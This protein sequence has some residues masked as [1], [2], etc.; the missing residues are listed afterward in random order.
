M[1]NN[2]LITVYIVN[3]NYG[4]YLEQAINSV[5]RQTIQNYEIIIIDNDS[6]DDSVEIISKFLK[7]K[8]ISV[9]FQK[10]IGLNATNNVAIKMAKG[11]YIMRLDADDY[12]DPNALQLMSSKLEKKKELGL[13]FPDYYTVDQDSNIIRNKK[14]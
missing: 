3:H 2:I 12:L 6:K 9:V 5:L 13:V 4:K 8:K 7:K 11:K 10:N 1:N 14:T